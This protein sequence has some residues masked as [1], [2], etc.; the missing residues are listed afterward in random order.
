MSLV[1]KEQILV[2]V[3]RHVGAISVVPWYCVILM[4]FMKCM[5]ICLTKRPLSSFSHAEFIQ[6]S[7]KLIADCCLYLGTLMPIIT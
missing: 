1:A 7:S 5:F 6:R 4:W 2:H 3:P